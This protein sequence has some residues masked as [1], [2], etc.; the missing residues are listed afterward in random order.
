MSVV[1]TGGGSIIHNNVDW[2]QWKPLEWILDELELADTTYVSK[3]EHEHRIEWRAIIEL[4]NQCLS[5]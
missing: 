4:G 1:A 3:L 2:Q 5:R